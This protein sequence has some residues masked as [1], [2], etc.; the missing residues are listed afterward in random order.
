[1]PKYCIIYEHLYSYKVQQISIHPVIILSIVVIRSL[2]FN[3]YA[4]AVLSHLFMLNGQS[5]YWLVSS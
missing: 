5:N 1:M 3:I 4:R 2:L